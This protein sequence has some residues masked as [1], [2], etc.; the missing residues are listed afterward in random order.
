MEPG[1]QKTDTKPKISVV[2]A[3]FDYAVVRRKFRES[4]KKK[5]PRLGVIPRFLGPQQ[6]VIAPIPCRRTFGRESKP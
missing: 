6:E 4:V 2:I 5:I 3:I 1:D